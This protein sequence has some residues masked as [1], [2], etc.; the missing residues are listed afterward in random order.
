MMLGVFWS[1]IFMFVC[2]DDDDDDEF[3]TTTI[4]ATFRLSSSSSSL[5]Q[6]ISCSLIYQLFP[7]TP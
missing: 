6:Q 4:T 2:G 1:R 5:Q 7:P 3:V